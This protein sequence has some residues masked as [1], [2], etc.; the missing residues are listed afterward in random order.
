M[1]K[2]DHIKMKINIVKFLFLV[3]LPK[4]EINSLHSYMYNWYYSDL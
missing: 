1:E 3:L 4:V 2:T